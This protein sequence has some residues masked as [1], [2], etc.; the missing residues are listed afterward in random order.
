VV[1]E[2]RGGFLEQE[3]M[4]LK[5]KNGELVTT[6]RDWVGHCR[7]IPEKYTIQAASRRERGL[8][9]DS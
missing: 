5:E 4:L 3:M 7:K 6:F 2:V 9:G 8:S 1:G